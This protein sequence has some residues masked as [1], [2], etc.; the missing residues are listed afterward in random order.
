[1]KRVKE[2][3]TEHLQDRLPG[4]GG[5]HHR[6]LVLLA[7]GVALGG[8]QGQADEDVHDGDEHHRHEEKGEGRELKEVLGVVSPWWR[9]VAQQSVVKVLQQKLH[10]S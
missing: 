4:L 8:R 5:R 10:V 6:R 3:L 1:M 9:D 7:V 2:E